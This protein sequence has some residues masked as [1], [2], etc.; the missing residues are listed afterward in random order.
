MAC[1]KL[2]DRIMSDARIRLPGAIDETMKIELFSLLD[3][4]FRRTM[5]W[6]EDIPIGVVTTKKTYE[7][8]SNE[9][10]ATI[11]ELLYVQNKD[12]IPIIA[13]MEVAGELLLHT[14]PSEDQIYTVRVALAL[15][16]ALDDDG[17]PQVPQ[18]IVTKYHEAF[19]DGLLSHM[20]MQPAK[21]YYNE[22]LAQYHGLRFRSAMSAAFADMKQRNVF[23]ASGWVFPQQF[24]TSRRQ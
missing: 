15:A 23:D 21:P 2:F 18:W 9:W 16:D 8:D 3:E 20:A 24:A 12:A 4:F 14:Y 11:H 7:I 1:A 17:Y 10:I 13:S 5:L 22:K 19:K 6:Q